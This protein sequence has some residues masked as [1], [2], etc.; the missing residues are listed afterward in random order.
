VT[1][2]RTGSHIAACALAAVLL[3]ALTGCQPYRI[4]Y[5]PRPAFYDQ[6]TDHELPDRVELDDGTVIIYGEPGD[7]SSLEKQAADKNRFKLRE[8]KDD[9]SI[10][11]HNLLPEHVLVNAFTCLRNEEYELLYDQL[12]AEQTK[13]AYESRID[14]DSESDRDNAGRAAFV[15]YAKKHRNELGAT[16]RRMLLGMQ[17]METVVDRKDSGVIELRLSPHVSSQFKFKRAYIVS[18]GFDLKLLT[19]R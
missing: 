1:L 10:E 19:V 17:R 13:M 14:N 9:G 4:E 18:E 3:A 7:K 16:L 11:L 5:R 15:A 6:A 2:R 8:K 12:L